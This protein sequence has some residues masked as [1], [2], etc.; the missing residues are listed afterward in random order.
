MSSDRTTGPRVTPGW[1]LALLLNLVPVG[2]DAAGSLNSHDSP[3][4]DEGRSSAAHALAQRAT[5]LRWIAGAFP[6]GI[7]TLTTADEAVLLRPLVAGEGDHAR[8]AMQQFLLHAVQVIAVNQPSATV[9]WWNPFDDAWV[10]TSWSL[11]AQHWRLE[12]TRA[13]LATDLEPQLGSAAA[14]PLHPLAQRLRSYEQTLRSGR[15]DSLTADPKRQDRAW[16]TIVER[17]MQHD[18]AMLKLSQ[19]P[20]YE[21]LNGLLRT[22]VAARSADTVVDARVKARLLA[23]P[24]TAVQTLQ[25]VMVARHAGGYTVIMQSPV[26]PALLIFA[27]LRDPDD[28]SDRQSAAVQSLNAGSLFATGAGK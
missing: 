26:A 9:G 3:T 1:A 18:A 13:L 4:A 20:G 19:V 24:K 21:Q 25:P 8:L 28:Q 16:S 10:I 7:S 2:A 11:Q 6:Q 22:A 12:R 5:A 14:L 15:L 17:Q 27:R 23:F